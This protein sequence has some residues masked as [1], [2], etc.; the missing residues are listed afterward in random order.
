[1]L[2][3]R[4][5]IAVSVRHVPL[6]SSVPVQIHSES[7]LLKL[8]LWSCCS[9]TPSCYCW[10]LIGLLRELR[11]NWGISKHIHPSAAA[12]LHLTSSIQFFLTNDWSFKRHQWGKP[13]FFNTSFVSW[14]ITHRAKVLTFNFQLS[15]NIQSLRKGLLHVICLFGWLVWFG[16]FFKAAEWFWNAGLDCISSEHCGLSQEQTGQAWK[17]PPLQSAKALLDFPHGSL[18]KNF[19]LVEKTG[20]SDPQTSE[21]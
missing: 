14:K 21:S 18:F 5:S 10:D 9:Q 13:Q 16:L 6:S 1:M 19:Q 3:T 7:Q 11:Q 2:T 12:R 4:G 17:H 20:S 8:D 15:N